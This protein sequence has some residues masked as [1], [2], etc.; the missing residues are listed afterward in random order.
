MKRL[1]GVFL[2]LATMLVAGCQL[3]TS[4]LD[5]GYKFG[6]LSRVYCASTSDLERSLLRGVIEGQ[7]ET[8]ISVDYCAGLEPLADGYDPGD[9]TRTV[10]TGL[11]ADT[12]AAAVQSLGVGGEE[13]LEGYCGVAG[14]VLK[15]PE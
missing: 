2:I 11:D 8:E 1:M 4:S 10:C 5:D 9:I 3:D 12:R 7:A 14:Y 6:D 13:Q 15:E